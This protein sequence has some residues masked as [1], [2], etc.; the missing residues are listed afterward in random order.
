M[1]NA[2]TGMQVFVN[3]GM[4]TEIMLDVDATDTISNVKEKIQDKEGIPPRDQRLNFDGQLLE[5]TRTLRDYNIQNESTLHL[6]LVVRG[7]M[8]INVFKTLGNVF[9]LNVEASDT[10][11]NVKAQIQDKEGLPPDQQRLMHD[12]IEL[13]DG[14][15]LSDYNI[16]PNT[17]VFLHEVCTCHICMEA[18]EERFLP[19]ARCLQCQ[20]PLCTSCVER[21]ARCP[22]CNYVPLLQTRKFW[23]RSTPY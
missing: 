17:L 8:Q 14:R 16:S 6:L 22:F 13:E 20:Q 11:N 1:A 15:T 7:S 10:I 18:F 2:R 3:I 5:D 4:F 9:T 19:A 23:S 21:L 12:G